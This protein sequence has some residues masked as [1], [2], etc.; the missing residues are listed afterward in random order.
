MAL[1][2]KQ[3]GLE[4]AQLLRLGRYLVVQARLTLPLLF[5]MVEAPALPLDRPFDKLILRLVRH[6]R[7]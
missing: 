7:I 3:L 4:P 2:V 1:L 6:T 5:L